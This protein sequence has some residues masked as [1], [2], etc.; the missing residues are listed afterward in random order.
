MDALQILFRIGD[1]QNFVSLTI[2]KMVLV[3]PV[4]LI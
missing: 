3:F 4:T 1:G 2:Y